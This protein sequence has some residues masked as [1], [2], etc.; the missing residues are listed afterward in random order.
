[1]AAWARGREATLIGLDP[2]GEVARDIQS[3]R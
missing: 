3:A 1:M 2:G